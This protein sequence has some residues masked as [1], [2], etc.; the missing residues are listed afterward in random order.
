[1]KRFGMF[2]IGMAVACGDHQT[3]QGTMNVVVSVQGIAIAEITRVTITVQP[4]N[5]TRDLALATDGTFTGTLTVATGTQTVTAAAYKGTS[6]AATSTAPPVEVQPGAQVSVTLTL[7]DSSGP[8]P[9]PDHSPVVLSFVVPNTDAMQGVAQTLTATAVDVDGD[10]IDVGWSAAPPGCGTFASSSS[11]P[12]APNG[13]S[14]TTVF[15]SALL[16]TCTVKVTATA[17]GKPDSRSTVVT[18][19]E[20]TG[21]I[22]V[23][24]SYYPQP[25][26]TSM[27]VYSGGTIWWEAARD[28]NDATSPSSVPT[29]SQHEVRASYDA[30][31]S[32]AVTLVDSCGGVV[33]G[34]SYFGGT[35][36]YASFQWTAAGSPN[37]CVLTATLTVPGPVGGFHD[38][39]P[40]VVRVGL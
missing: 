20:A 30:V 32:A 26:I 12:I 17:N 27:A 39:F 38:E 15:T 13:V 9:L 19:V 1:M 24:G 40:I 4:A 3:N 8:P 25:Y 23:S 18:V 11:T 37:A 35:P 36:A 22:S 2:A 28:G 31:Q 21:T 33:T 29:S 16:G 7:Y 6:L 5:V 10:A 14:A 34:P